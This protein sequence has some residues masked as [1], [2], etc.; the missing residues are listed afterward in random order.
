M[1]VY[2]TPAKVNKA[3]AKA[4]DDVTI[5]RGNGYYYFDDATTAIRSIYQ[6]P[7]LSSTPAQIVDYVRAELARI[8]GE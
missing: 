5:V 2:T 3:L 4:F 8:K 1:T 6:W 7:R